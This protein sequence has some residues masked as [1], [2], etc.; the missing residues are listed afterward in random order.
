MSLV[1]FVPPITTH[2]LIRTQYHLLL[3]R[4]NSSPQDV[5]FEELARC[6]VDF[7]GAQLKAVCTEAGMKALRRNAT[8][9]KH[10]VRACD[11]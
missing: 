9:L 5:N 10:E 1:R 2:L 4:A 6:T 3:V 8:E 7:N 11:M